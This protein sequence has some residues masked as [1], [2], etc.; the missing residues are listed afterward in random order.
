MRQFGS[1]DNAM[2]IHFLILMK[3]FLKIAILLPVYF[4]NGN[5]EMYMNIKFVIYD[6]SLMI[7]AWYCITLL[8][9]I[10]CSGRL[11]Y[12]SHFKDG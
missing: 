10:T 8:I 5:S 2:C 11:Y 3:Y 7:S 12:Y 6:P 1:R 4:L 9:L